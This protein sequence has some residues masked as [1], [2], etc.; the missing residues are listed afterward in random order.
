[1]A[2]SMAALLM[3]LPCMVSAGDYTDA[4]TKQRRCEAIGKLGIEA[5]TKKTV[6]GK[7]MPQL[8][9]EQKQGKI[10]GPFLADMYMVYSAARADDVHSEK[11]AYM[12]AWAV[13]MDDFHA[14]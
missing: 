14:K 5:Y 8:A 13:C 11:D 2:R 4:V 12:A 7:T 1:M 10:Q 9:E 6:L 3:I